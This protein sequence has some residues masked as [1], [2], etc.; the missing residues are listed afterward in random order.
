[1]PL[2]TA[3]KIGDSQAAVHAGNAQAALSAARAAHALEP[4][5]ASPYV[6]LALVEEKMGSI[7][8]AL[9][10]ITSAI[11]RDSTDWQLWLIAARL[12]VKAGQLQ[13][14]KAT[15]E[16]ALALNPRSPLLKRLVR[17]LANS[18]S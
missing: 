9:V 15:L 2:L 11:R 1:L 18:G 12:W 5:A 4:W 10:S 17:V 8:A 16:R 7:P 13:S 3:L 14:A 6:Q